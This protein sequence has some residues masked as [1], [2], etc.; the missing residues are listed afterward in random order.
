M[1]IMNLRLSSCPFKTASMRVHLLKLDLK[2][3]SIQNRQR[4]Q[5]L[6]MKLRSMAHRDSIHQCLL[7]WK[8]SKNLRKRRL[9]NS[10]TFLS[11]FRI[12]K[13]SLTNFKRNSKTQKLRRLTLR[14]KQKS[15]ENPMKKQI[16]KLYLC[17]KL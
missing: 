4:H 3:Q 7:F 6:E 2:E 15:W 9:S 13:A 14:R 12:F 11:R 16:R 10:R 8:I 1:G 17:R 5:L